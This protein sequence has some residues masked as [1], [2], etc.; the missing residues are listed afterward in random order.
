MEII[1]LDWLERGAFMV[2]SFFIGFLWTKLKAEKE[3][4]NN[5]VEGIRALLRGRIRDI[6]ERAMGRNPKY[7]TYDE[8][9]DAEDIYSAYHKLRGNGRGTA[10]IED[11]QRLKVRGGTNTWKE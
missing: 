11:L 8:L 5:I 2:L 3:R 10:L 7:V 4:Q 9:Q 1:F 6:H